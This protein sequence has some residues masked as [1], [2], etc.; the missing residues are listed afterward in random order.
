MLVSDALS[1]SLLLNLTIFMNCVHFITSLQM[2][3]LGS[4]ES[5]TWSKAHVWVSSL[6]TNLVLVLEMLS[7]L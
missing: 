1:G 5:L 4:K 6:V 3:F 7:S 2:K